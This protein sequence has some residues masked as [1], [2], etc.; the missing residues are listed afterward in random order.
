M[1]VSS[2][3]CRSVIAMTGARRP[4]RQRGRQFPGRGSGAPYPCPV[5]PPRGARRCCSRPSPCCPTASP[6]ATCWSRP[7]PSGHRRALGALGRPGRRLGRGRPGRRARHLGLPPALRGL[8]GLGPAVDEATHAAQRRRGLRLER[9]QGL[10]RRDRRPGAGRPIVLVDDRDLAA[11]C[12]PALDRFGAVVVKAAH[13]RERG[14]VVVQAERTDDHRLSGLTEGPWIVQP[15]VESVRTRG[16]DL[17]VRARRRARSPR[18]TSCRAAARSAC[19]SSTAGCR[20]RCRWATS[21]RRSAVAAMAAVGDLLG[22]PLDYGRV[23]L[24]E[25]DGPAGRQRA[26]ADRAR[27]LPRRAARE[28]RAV[29]RP[30]AARRR[31]SVR[32]ALLWKQLLHSSVTDYPATA[33]PGRTRRPRRPRSSRR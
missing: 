18:S 6:A 11:A 8:P 21:P 33:A 19:T 26:R 1:V 29:R 24:M 14:R 2:R 31:D 9:R 28:R 10:P 27:A 15:L 30:G 12:G 4:D 20:G 25:H 22:R 3:R 17:G 23:D 5:T 13:R 7:S 16:R 32:D